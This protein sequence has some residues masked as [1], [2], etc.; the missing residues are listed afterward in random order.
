MPVSHIGLT[1]SH[2]PTSCSFFLS[3]LQPLG[4]RFIGQE[5]NQIGLGIYDADFFLCQETPG[6]KAGAAHIAFSAPSRSVVNAFFRAALKAGGRP[7]GEPATRDADKGYYNAAVLDFDGNSIEVVHRDGLSD[8]AAVLEGPEAR[9]VLTWQKS[10]AKSV[11]GNSKPPASEASAN[12][13]AAPAPTVKSQVAPVATEQAPPSNEGPSTKTLIGTLLGA[14]AG[15]AVA[16]AM[17]KG[18]SM[19][20]DS[21][22]KP[23]PPQG[24]QRS[25]EPAATP[26]PAKEPE[27]YYIPASEIQAGASAAGRQ[28]VNYFTGAHSA[29]TRPSISSRHTVDNPSATAITRK[30]IEAPPVVRQ[31]STLINTYVPSEAPRAIPEYLS[32]VSASSKGRKSKSKAGSSHHSSHSHHSHRSSR[33]RSRSRSHSR[34]SAATN[35]TYHSAKDIPL[36]A[37]TKASTAAAAN[38]PLPASSGST[39]AGTVVTAIRN[40]TPPAPTAQTIVSSVLGRGANINDDADSIAPSDS[41]SQIGSM[42]SS[43]HRSPSASRSRSRS[44][45]RSGSSTGSHKSKSKA[46]SHTSDSPRSQ[47]SSQRTI[48]PVLRTQKASSLILGRNQAGR[49]S[50]P[51]KASAFS[52]PLRTSSRSPRPGF[53]NVPSPLRMAFA[54]PPAVGAAGSSIES[55][56]GG[57]RGWE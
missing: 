12:S 49:S 41:V 14:A 1:V 37:S 10:V 51:S 17:V 47:T 40:G 7:N 5:G 57:A 26:A 32:V 30:A 18:D 11:S 9:R 28:M 8:Q 31:P 25:I 4:Y 33:S 34:V 23:P 55:I 35:T 16:Y 39:A 56:E 21:E 15:A 13:A 2:L 53:A 27:S 46:K 44:R 43:H 38:T 19:S 22:S 24:V 42:H 45:S 29:Y 3:S 54:P 20:A 48:R 50:S 36:P 52:L 6:I